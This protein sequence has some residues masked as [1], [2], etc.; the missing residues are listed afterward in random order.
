MNKTK[1]IFT[2]REVTLLS[3][4]T[5]IILTGSAI[6]PV[7]PRILEVFKETPHAPF[8]T[9]M[10]LSLPAL[11]IA[12][13]SPLVGLILDRWG[14]KPVLLV[15]LGLYG[16]IG[17]SA[18]LLD[19]LYAI[20]ISRAL[21]GIGIAGIVTSSIT[22][23]G[24]YYSGVYR[25]RFMGL[26]SAVTGYSGVAYITVAGVLG[27]VYW[28]LPFLIYLLALLIL[29]IAL[30]SITEPEHITKS[31][32]GDQD[33]SH[34]KEP[35][36]TKQIAFIYFISFFGMILFYMVPVQLPF[37]MNSLGITSK[38][39]IGSS[40]AVMTLVSAT[41]ATQFHRIKERLSF[42]QIFIL[43]FTLMGTGYFIIGTSSSYVQIIIATSVSGLGLGL[44]MP[45]LSVYI[46][47]IAPEGIR[48][49]I[50][51]GMGTAFFLGQFFSPI[52]VHP[53]VE[54]IGLARSF[55]AA[56]GLMLILTLILFISNYR[57]TRSHTS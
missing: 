13:A 41:T 55:V 30:F 19:S 4:S 12:L 24:D 50:V 32:A 10:I 1:T 25:I 27:D 40:M 21:L 46:V 35:L 36:P 34:S 15:S 45:S 16:F 29:P 6:A 53:S 28:R 56:S 48:G 17:A 39:M 26:Q 18:Y 47:S 14:R 9:R 8:L 33:E 20:L 31:K 37:F 22:L 11:S 5:M 7:L 43:L 44:F 42:L 57:N 3:A 52:I 38:T 23:I 2:L 49:R 54:A 51:G